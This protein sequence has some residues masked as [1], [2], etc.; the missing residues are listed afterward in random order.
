[1]N[2][3]K[4]AALFLVK[5]S[6]NT[7]HL[8]PRPAFA[9]LST[10]ESEVYALVATLAITMIATQ[11]NASAS[12]DIFK[13]TASA[14]PS[15]PLTR[16]TSMEDASATMDYLSTTVSASVLSFALSTPAPIKSPDAASA[17]LDSQ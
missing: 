8:S 16:L 3:P 1:M 11:I 13:R 9:T 15:A 12:Q 14:I 10:S 6:T 4:H 5:E 2:T 17:T 7:I